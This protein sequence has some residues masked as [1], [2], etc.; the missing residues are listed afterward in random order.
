MDRFTIKGPVKLQGEV[1][2]SGSKNAA[3]PILM[4]T[5]LTDE[6]CVL[7]RVPNLRDIRTT[8]KLL[9]VLGKKVEY[10]NG[11]AVITKNKELNSIL[12][13][14]LVKQMRA[15]F[16]V[17]G[18]LLARLKHTQIPLPGG[19][20]IGVRPVDIHLQ[21]FKKFGAAESTKKG[22]V[23][24]SAD[25]LKPAKIVLR[26]PSVGATINIMMC[27]SLIPGKT[28]IENAAKEPE[29]EDL[30][31]A[32]KTMGAQISI[33]SKGR[34]IV[35]GKKTLGSMTHTVV[36]DRIET[37]TFI[38]A[39]AATKG[40]VV[41]KNCVPEHNDIL[42]EN[43]KDAGFGVSVGQGRIHITAPS[44][45]KIKPVGIRTMPYPGFATD[46]QAPYMVLLCV[47][48]GGSDITEDIFENRYMHAPEL[49][50]MGADIT[51][52]KTMA[53]VKGVKELSGANVMAS[54]LRGGAALV[55]AALCAAGDTVIDRVYHIDRGYENIEA[56][57]AALGAKIVRDNPLKD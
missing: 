48:D 31:C 12:P 27:A 35:E 18:P 36:A 10:N 17:A 16:W 1:E 29:V 8:F 47:A 43:L 39:A 30:I 57:F 41:I 22:D 51:I 34:I 3:L 2:I 46:L 6:K 38:L 33:D 49:V 54:D 44:N 23:V 24:I 56:K 19:C 25:E 13:Y 4:A 14:E 9:E 37:G 45:G 5:L 21:G 53:K 20:A 28:I 40:D 42:L 7:N 15:S 50:R 26:F 11:T 32:L 55:I 52:E